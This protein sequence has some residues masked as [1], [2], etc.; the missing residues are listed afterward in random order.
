M[1][2]IGSTKQR[3]LLRTAGNIL[4]VL[5]L[6]FCTW[7]TG[8][9]TAWGWIAHAD[10]YGAAFRTAGIAVFAL[11]CGM[12]AAV[13]LCLLRHDLSAA[14]LGTVSGTALLVIMLLTVSAAERYGW[15]GQTEAGF[16]RQASAVWRR[17]L[18]GNLLTLTLLLLLSLTRFFSAGAA[19]ER[20]ARRNARAEREN[21]PAPSLLGGSTRG[22]T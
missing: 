10:H 19:A 20:A 16:S 22:D 21:E 11:N 9:A 17:G 14:V 18:G 15:S 2:E 12:T 6:L 5:S 1:R 8:G 3:H 13:L 4:L 7:L